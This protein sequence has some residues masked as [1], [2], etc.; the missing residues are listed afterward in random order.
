M[1]LHKSKEVWRFSIC[2]ARPPSGGLAT[3]MASTTSLTNWSHRLTGS[4][5]APPST[6]TFLLLSVLFLRFHV[7]FCLARKQWF[8]VWGK[9]GKSTPFTYFRGSA[10]F[11]L[12]SHA[13][14]FAFMAVFISPFLGQPNY[15]CVYWSLVCFKDT[16]REI[17]LAS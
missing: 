15:L 16:Q 4:Q 13:L 9:M 14:S 17:S 2:W 7:R 5:Q 10:E 6:R 3:R 11:D 1:V 8:Y 12:P